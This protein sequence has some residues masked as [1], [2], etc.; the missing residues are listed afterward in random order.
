M[1]TQNVHLSTSWQHKCVLL[2]AVQVCWI[3][4]CVRPHL[5][6]R[7]EMISSLLSFR[8]SISAAADL[9]DQSAI[10][11]RCAPTSALKTLGN[12]TIKRL[13][14][15][16]RWR[17]FP[18]STHRCH[19]GRRQPNKTRWAWWRWFNFDGFREGILAQL[20]Y[21]NRCRRDCV[22]LVMCR[23][24]KASLTN[25]NVNTPRRGRKEGPS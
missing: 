21:I 12:R 16:L 22:V 8:R 18:F 20:W 1:V 4:P 3:P 17:L 14:R 19:L 2:L 6:R 25:T 9:I 13:Y 11:G 15:A 10:R 7:S 5:L 23:K 24:T